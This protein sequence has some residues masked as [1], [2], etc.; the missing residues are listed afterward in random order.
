MKSITDNFKQD[1][2]AR[3]RVKNKFKKYIILK[4]LKVVMRLS[5]K[6]SVS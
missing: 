6:N 1:Y 5:L 2:S 4:S 3:E